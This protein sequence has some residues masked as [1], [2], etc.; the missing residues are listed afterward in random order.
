MDRDEN[1]LYRVAVR[2]GILKG[3]YSRNQFDLC[4]QLHSIEHM[5]RHGDV[6]LCQAVQSESRCGG[7]GY[8][9]CN[10]AASG[11]QMSDKPM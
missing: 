8:T 11:K 4:T 9:K 6:G 5:P 10:C 7:Q 2:A 1:D 3:R